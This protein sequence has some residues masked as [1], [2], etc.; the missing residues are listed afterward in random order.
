[1]VKFTAAVADIFAFQ[2]LI[3]EMLNLVFGRLGGL[4][5]DTKA[6]TWP[7]FLL[8]KPQC[9][10]LIGQSESYKVS[11]LADLQGLGRAQGETAW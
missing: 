4:Q 9:R 7:T 10:N 1:M 6:A 2:V 8:N 5:G 3:E 11:F